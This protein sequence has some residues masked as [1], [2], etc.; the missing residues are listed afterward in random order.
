LD[1]G[2]K[3]DLILVRRRVPREEYRRS[4]FA[5]AALFAALGLFEAVFVRHAQINHTALDYKGSWFTPEVGYFISFCF[6]AMAA[7]LLVSAFRRSDD[8]KD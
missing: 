7:C 8:Q 4:S 1:L 5:G 3:F 6:F 2:E